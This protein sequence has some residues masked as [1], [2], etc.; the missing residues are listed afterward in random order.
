MNAQWDG[1]PEQ[2]HP[3]VVLDSNV[4]LDL[5]FFADR[6]VVALRQA[7]E[8]GRLCWV[9]APALQE[10]IFHVLLQGKIGILERVGA[11]KEMVFQAF[12]AWSQPHRTPLVAADHR[13]RCTD[14]DDQKFIDLALSMAPAWLLSRDK[15]VLKLAKRAAALGVRIATP[16]QWIAAATSAADTLSAA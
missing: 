11:N 10:E 3:T 5:W 1:S 9:T 6:R 12:S 4:V 7:V 15:A 13:L 14:A 8:N 2:P 16:E